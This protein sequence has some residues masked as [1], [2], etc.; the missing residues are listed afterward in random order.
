MATMPGR[1]FRKWVFALLTSL[2]TIT[3]WV[4][5]HVSTQHLRVFPTPVP[6]PIHIHNTSVALVLATTKE[7]NPDWVSEIKIPALQVIRYIADDPG[8]PLTP[9]VNK[10]NEAMIYFSYIYRFYDHLPDVVIFT[11]SS[12]WAWHN[13]NIFDKSNVAALNR[14]DIED[15]RRRRY[16]N[17]KVEDCPGTKIRT[18]IQSN[19]SEGYDGNHEEEPYMKGFF[20]NNFDAEVPEYFTGACCSQIAVSK[21]AIMRVPREQYARHIRWL[22]ESEL[23]DYMLGRLWERLWGYLFLGEADVCP[24]LHVTLCSQYHICFESAADW[25]RWDRLWHSREDQMGLKDKLLELEQESGEETGSVGRE[26]SGIRALEFGIE[27][28]QMLLDEMR[29]RAI[30]RGQSEVARKKITGELWLHNE[31]VSNT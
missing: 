9:R 11:H 27:T 20:Q 8:A 15:V 23:T 13:D 28:Q 12:D 18:Y 3:A 31:T 5:L 30:E 26:R 29:N 19:E 4:S 2:L 1:P 6:E 7:D 21:E 16:V 22:E 25:L 14:L 10:G 17:L 24:D